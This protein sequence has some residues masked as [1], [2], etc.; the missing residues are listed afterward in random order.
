M[1]SSKKKHKK[2][3][4]KDKEREKS[5]SKSS[6]HGSSRNSSNASYNS[7]INNDTPLYL[8]EQPQHNPWDDKQQSTGQQSTMLKPLRLVLKVP[9]SYSQTNAV[10][11][12]ITTTNTSTVSEPI[13]VQSYNNHHQSVLTTSTPSYLDPIKSTLSIDQNIATSADISS[14]MISTNVF[15]SNVQTN[16]STSNEGGVVNSQESSVNSL[17]YVNS[18]FS[19][20]SN[21]LLSKKVKKSKKSKKSKHR[22]HSH[23]HK[24]SHKK[25]HHHILPS[26]LS[27]DTTTPLTHIYD[28]KS[29]V[30]NK[31]ST[32]ELSNSLPFQSTIDHKIATANYDTPSTLKSTKD[33]FGNN[34]NAA[35]QPATNHNFSTQ[36]FQ[37]LEL[38]PSNESE[39]K[40][41]WHFTNTKTTFASTNTTSSS[42]DPV[43]QQSYYLS[44]SSNASM[45]Q[46]TG[47]EIK[48]TLSK[49]SSSTQYS[50]NLKHS[51]SKSTS[52][53]VTS[54]IVPPLIISPSK[55]SSPFVGKAS[56]PINAV[57]PPNLNLQNNSKTSSVIT[58]NTS[59]AVS[60][61]KMLNL[62]EPLIKSFKLS[63]DH[64]KIKKS[65]SEKNFQDLLFYLL[66][67][68][69]KK[70]S[71]GFFAKPVSDLIAPGYSSIIAH[72]MDL[73]T[74]GKNITS[75]HY[76]NLGDF[77]A[78]VKLMCD[79]AM[80]YNRVETIYYKSANKLWHYTK[81]KLF[82]NSSLA[83]FSKT[84]VKCTPMD[85]S[86]NPTNPPSNSKHLSIT[87]S[88]FNITPFNAESTSLSTST[89]FTGTNL[90][91]S[92]PKSTE[93][94]N[95]LPV[96]FGGIVPM[97]S[98]TPFKLDPEPSSAVTAEV[99]PTPT[100]NQTQLPGN[101]N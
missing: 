26:V 1:G 91:K 70:D 44:S 38:K 16:M 8:V 79:N 78:D 92:S 12:I 61:P 49:A 60:E 101:Y 97:T 95:S 34:N 41:N 86:L 58:S 53:N 67:Q 72:P 63:N 59:T 27:G 9:P 29:Q 23:S 64:K 56:Q 90:L 66:R 81:N 13:S 21:K 43:T 42:E 40:L 5:K 75:G 48:L 93:A 100:Q 57:V 51:P 10:K 28:L 82:K 96:G 47:P 52:L 71:Q 73:S 85:L 98:S 35:T 17:H 77:K 99:T 30:E 19:V 25:H 37:D 24:H 88:F 50:S 33:L 18:L 94:T 11:K 83:E 76:R 2:N 74:I 65:K 36:H 39:S 54:Q 87:T 14:K 31:P 6:S 3:K 7:I 22:K 62:K 69:T 15:N 32:T 46:K 89:T 68:L 4:D 80:K 20:S 84:Y 55:T 45:S